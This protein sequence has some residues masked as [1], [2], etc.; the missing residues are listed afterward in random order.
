MS[1]IA[2]TTS[3]D[4]CRDHAACL[5]HASFFRRS[6]WCGLCER[7]IATHFIGGQSGVPSSLLVLCD[8]CLLSGDGCPH[9]IEASGTMP[10]GEL[11]VAV[12]VECYDWI[13]SETESLHSP[14]NLLDIEDG[15]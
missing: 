4:V 9:V 12:C 11:V 14:L 1:A 15:A 5:R 13:L 2:T 3:A 7:R 6:Q 8:V 10:S